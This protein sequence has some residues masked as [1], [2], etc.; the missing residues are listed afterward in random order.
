MTKGK[1]KHV[2]KPIKGGYEPPQDNTL[3]EIVLGSIIIDKYAIEY[4][5]V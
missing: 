1:P 2:P 5:P 4:R 3:E